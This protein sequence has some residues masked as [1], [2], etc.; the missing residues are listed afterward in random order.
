[1]AS[2]NVTPDDLDI[3]TRTMLGED[4]TPEGQR[5]VAHV[6]MN[7]ARSGDYPDSPS[8]VA[9]QK[10]QFEPW[11]A[12]RRE[13]MGYSTSS[14]AYQRAYAIAKGVVD[15]SV[16]DNTG[17]AVNFWAPASQEK[18]GRDPPAWAANRTPSA[19]IAGQLY[20]TAPNAKAGAGAP[21]T[22]ADFLSDFEIAPPAVSAGK[23]SAPDTNAGPA[24]PGSA[25]AAA[26]PTGTPADFHGLVVPVEIPAQAKPSA[27]GPADFEKD[28]A[29]APPPNAAPA[30]AT[31][32]PDVGTG[33]AYARGLVS[34]VPVVGP[35]ITGGMDRLMAYQAS[36][37][38]GTPYD[39]ELARVQA[40]NAAQE[41]MHPTATTAGNVSGAVLGTGAAA[42]R[43]PAL[44]GISPTAG[45]L[46]NSATSALSGAGIGATD[47]LIRS[48]GDTG[49]ALRQG[50]IGGLLG[51]A[52]PGV[53]KLVGSGLGAAYNALTGVSP[54][55]RN[56]ASIFSD[57][58]MTPQGARN[59]LD[60]IGPNATLA[61]IN[62]ALT[63]E[64]GG[65][66]SQG[67]EPTSI[68]RTRMAARAAGAD[69]RVSQSVDQMLGP[70][71]D[72]TAV[73]ESIVNDAQTA[74]GPHYAAARA[75]AQPMNV[76]PVVSS[77]DTQLHDAVGGEA[78]ILS[79][80]R[81]YLTDANG[82]VK[83]DPQALLKVRQQLDDDIGSL[84]RNGTIDGTSSGKNAY[85]TANDLRNRLDAVLKTDPNIAAGDAAFAAHMRVKDAVDVGNGL[86]TKGVRLEDFQR[87]LTIM[88]P[89]EIDAVRQGARVAIGDALE[90][91]RRGE[92][93]GAQQ[94]FGRGSA[95]RAKLDALFP[96]A[97]DVFDMLHGEA[98]M[99]STEQRV[100]QNSA[101]AER[102][103]VQ[104]KY[105]PS[106]AQPLDMA[107]ALIGEAGSA[108]AGGVGA[109]GALGGKMILDHVRNALGSAAL[110]R[111][112][113]GTA[114]ALSAT[115]ASLNNVLADISRAAGTNATHGLL[116]QGGGGAANVLFRGVSPYA[117]P[118]SNSPSRGLLPLQ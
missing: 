39:A 10:D 20:Y 37:K 50:E 14:P 81:D 45:L 2:S 77:I 78:K 89:A 69:N 23:G 43:A 79:K 63:V 12:R 101:T 29:I 113:S 107:A 66:A 33:P 22:P 104:K 31:P 88:P 11:S 38:F 61:D 28:F 71:P 15:G 91:A 44:L 6:I 56:V 16:S 118:Q 62:P 92:L 80:A 100:A 96:N 41:G 83:T 109:I 49:E 4:A 51:A 87:A 36:Q 108:A 106:T 58:G 1:M 25:P 97:S 13:L 60:R 110:R 93:Q 8:A 24:L 98:A 47:A 85:R 86:F 72:L 3:M 21:S 19:A 103:A 111:L 32:A 112:T 84:Q 30:A 54:A 53:G 115:G 73:K 57:I 70:K 94:M 17:G 27:A 5:A 42:L 82:N 65:L 95:N 40:F 46:A 55:A 90:Q 76:T 26:A 48:G 102:L 114:N 68:L 18:L 116:S 59:A 64:A 99:R 74:A 67:G 105:S 117:L 35:L 75:N 9:L 7:R 52:A 34:G